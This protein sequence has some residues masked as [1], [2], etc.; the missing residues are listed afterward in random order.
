MHLGDDRPPTVLEALHHPQLP[1]RLLAVEGLCEDAPGQVAQLIPAARRRDRR[2]ANVIQD[3]EMRVV[4]PHRASDAGGGET[5]LL[6]VARHERQLGGDEADEVSICRSRT[7]EHRHRPD[8][9]RIVGVLD[10]EERRVLHAH[11]IHVMSLQVPATPRGGK[12]YSQRTAADLRGFPLQGIQSAAQGTA[13]RRSSGITV[14][15]AT[16]RP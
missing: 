9:H 15:H 5:H 11:H 2:V 6:P 10:V 8:V 16:H 13:W 4:D 14:P 12:P 1:E 3:L 7:L